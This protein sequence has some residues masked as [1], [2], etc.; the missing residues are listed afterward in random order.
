MPPNSLILDIWD[1][2]KAQRVKEA[3]RKVS[4]DFYELNG[5]WPQGTF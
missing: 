3:R 1:E 4:Q 2:V 5:Y